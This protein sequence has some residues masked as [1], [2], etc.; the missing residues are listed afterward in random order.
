MGTVGQAEDLSLWNQTRLHLNP[1]YHFLAIVL[2]KLLHLLTLSFLI[3]K[4]GATN[5]SQLR[6]CVRRIG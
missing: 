5:S 4:I 6:G 1:D 2:G 3:Y